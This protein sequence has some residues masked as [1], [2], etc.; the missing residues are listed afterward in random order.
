[1]PDDPPSE[2][3][4]E[5]VARLLL[6]GRCVEA[7]SGAR[8][9]VAADPGEALHHRLLARALMGQSRHEE[10]DEAA[11]EA[12]RLAPDDVNSLILV[13]NAASLQGDAA[14]SLAAAERAVA[15]AP[16]TWRTHYTLANAYLTDRDCRS[17]RALEAA[18][19]AVRLDPGNAE[20]HNIRGMC[21]GR[22]GRKDEERAAYEES[23]RCNP[24]HAPALNNL[25][26]L[27]RLRNPS[28][29]AEL[30]SRAATADP[31]REQIQRNLVGIVHN[32]AYRTLW[33]VVLYG[34]LVAVATRL[35]ASPW[36]RTGLLGLLLGVLVAA[37]VRFTGLLPLDLPRSHVWGRL[38]LRTKALLA[39]VAVALV[40]VTGLALT[41]PTSGV[42]TVLDAIDWIL[43][44]WG[45]LGLLGT[46]LVSRRAGRT[47]SS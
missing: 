35:G 21:L 18:D 3:A 16:E 42:Q 10:A 33:S 23:L 47:T 15:L 43:V 45:V 11:R 46:W 27:D 5:R 32:A 24:R 1:M 12:L 14:W 25:A 20:A 30:L 9:L 44:C 7:E 4:Q 22:L 13:A 2:S 8:E 41:P 40:V 31:G 26:L 38:P 37:T 39:L 34:V 28:R 6:V 17:E 29:A 36:V 19:E